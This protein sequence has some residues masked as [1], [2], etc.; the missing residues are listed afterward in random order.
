MQAYEI[1]K[2][3]G[4]YIAA[5]NGVDAIVF[6]GGI[7]ENGVWLR[8]KVCSYLGY[9]GVYINEAINEKTQKGKEAELTDPSDK[10]RV[11]I[12]ATDEELTIARDTAEIVG[13]IK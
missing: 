2:Y 12:L 5:M 8:S 3:I 1:A 11:F 9:M 7:G 6:T 13:S 4:S 10:V